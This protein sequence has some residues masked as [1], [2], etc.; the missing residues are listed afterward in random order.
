MSDDRKWS[1]CITNRNKVYNKHNVL[2]SSQD[3]SP[4]PPPSRSMEKLSSMKPVPV[5]KRLGTIVLSHIHEFWYKFLN[6]VKKKKKPEGGLKWG[7][8]EPTQQSLTGHHQQLKFFPRATWSHRRVF[9]RGAT[10]SDLFFCNETLFSVV[11]F[12]TDLRPE[13]P[14]IQVWRD[15]LLSG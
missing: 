11:M 4:P 8:E 10:M 14:K 6:S 5:S 9:R 7:E 1:W 12:Q 15:G 3:H 13:L 2:Q